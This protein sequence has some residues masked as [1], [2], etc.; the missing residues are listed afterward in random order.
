MLAKK[1]NPHTGKSEYCLESVTSKGKVLEWYGAN[2]PSEKRVDK[3][4]KRVQY[5]KNKSKGGW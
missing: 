5:F 4:E 1:V 2:K 3:S